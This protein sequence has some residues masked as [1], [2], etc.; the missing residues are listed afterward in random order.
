ML[1]ISQR[2][3]L[4]TEPRIHYCQYSNYSMG[5]NSG[6]RYYR[7]GEP[8]AV[9]FVLTQSLYAN[10]FFF[11]PKNVPIPIW[12]KLLHLGKVAYFVSYIY[13]VSLPA[14]SSPQ[15][16]R[17]RTK[18]KLCPT[19]DCLFYPCTLQLKI[20]TLKYNLFIYLTL[21]IKQ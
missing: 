11:I 16:G 6:P 13:I 19:F 3:Y 18:Q 8:F 5:V 15:A 17:R 14:I 21:Y 1:I 7:N 4:G 10:P 9:L 2:Y 12:Y 20:V